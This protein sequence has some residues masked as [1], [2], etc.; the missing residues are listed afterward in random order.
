MNDKTRFVLSVIVGVIV[1]YYA[2]AMYSFFPFNFIRNDSV[3]AVGFSTLIICTV[4]A[5]CTIVVKDN[6]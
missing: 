6:K 5:I 1:S 4:I 3:G 2:G